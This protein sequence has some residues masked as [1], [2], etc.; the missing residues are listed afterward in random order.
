MENPLRNE[1][2]AYQE[3]KSAVTALVEVVM[4]IEKRIKSG[5]YISARKQLH[6]RR[7]QRTVSH[8]LR[9][10]APGGMATGKYFHY[11]L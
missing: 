1:Q 5:F 8:E 2:H 4:E 7:F 6:C 3:G 11:P 10:A 9:V